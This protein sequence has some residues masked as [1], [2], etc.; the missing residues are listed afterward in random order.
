MTRDQVTRTL[1]EMERLRMDRDEADTPADEDRLRREYNHLWASIAPYVSG[2]ERC[3][4]DPP[5]V[6]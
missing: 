1:M 5:D 6:S 3:S 2:A 4:D